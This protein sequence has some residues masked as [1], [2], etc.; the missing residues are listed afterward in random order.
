M[1]EKIEEKEAVFIFAAIALIG[2]ARDY[3]DSEYDLMVKRCFA[4]GEKMVEEAKK[5]GLL[6]G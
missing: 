4:I 6:D 3:L 1:P 2:T 5:K